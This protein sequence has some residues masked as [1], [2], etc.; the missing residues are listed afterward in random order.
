MVRENINDL[1]PKAF[2][3]SE[4]IN[5]M[6]NNI[7]TFMC[8][9]LCIT[10]SACGGNSSQSDSTQ[11]L[12]FQSVFEGSMPPQ[13]PISTPTVFVIRSAT[14][15]TDFWKFSMTVPS[16]MPSINFNENM[17]LAV[18]DGTQSVD[19]YSIT[20]TVV[21]RTSDGVIVQ[22]VE[23]APG[24]N[25]SVQP[26][27]NQPFQIITTANISGGATLNLSKKITNCTSPCCA[28]RHKGTGT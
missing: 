24:Q 28:E 9:A 2:H 13:N 4:G 22:A 1:T 14:E 16:S 18:V 17:F 7:F 27:V 23:N 5:K 20:I 19:G 21:Q 3:D 26:W 25:C 10:L 12:A 15:W 8:V 11:Q 6:K